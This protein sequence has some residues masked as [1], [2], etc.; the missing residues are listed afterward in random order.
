MRDNLGIVLR[1][2][3]EYRA[4]ESML[5][6]T[7]SRSARLLGSGHPRTRLT[8]EAL[9]SVLTATGRP[10][11]AQRLLARIPRRNRRGTK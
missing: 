3:G 6:D 11:E 8:T 1:Q 4:A 7:R 2:L 5:R 9:A 10:F